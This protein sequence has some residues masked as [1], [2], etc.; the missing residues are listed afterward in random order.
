MHKSTESS[1]AM[2]Q[3]AL[4]SKSPL[5]ERTHQTRVRAILMPKQNARNFILIRVPG[6]FLFFAIK[7]Y[8]G[9][10]FSH[11]IGGTILTP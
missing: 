4:N 9:V 6:G 10:T 3:G 11:A 1:V 7:C 2:N 5:D 8:P